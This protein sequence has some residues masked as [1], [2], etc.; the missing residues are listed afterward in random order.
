MGVN[1]FA[2]PQLGMLSSHLLWVNR[3]GSEL[4]SIGATNNSPYGCGLLFDRAYSSLSQP[5]AEA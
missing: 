3:I 1:H 2:V 4:P 5:R